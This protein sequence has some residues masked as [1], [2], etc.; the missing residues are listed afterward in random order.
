MSRSYELPLFL[1]A[2]TPVELVTR[3]EDYSLDGS[4]ALLHCETGSYH[5]RIYSAYGIPGETVLQP[6]TP[7]A[8]ATLRLDFC[9]AEIVRLRYSP[10]PDVPD[11]TT[12]MVVGQF[13]EPV[14]VALSDDDATVTFETT[15]LRVVVQRD[16]W[17]IQ[18]YN[19]QNRCI[20]RTRPVEL[21]PLQRAARHA[22]LTEQH[23]LFVH[24][25]AYPLGVAPETNQVFCSF[26]LHHDERIY[27][28]GGTSG[29]LDKHGTAQRLWL[30]AAAGSASPATAQQ[31]PFFM[32]SAGYGL[33][34]NT[35]NALRVNVGDLDHTAMSVLL[36]DST[37]LDAYLIYGPTMRD[38]LPRYTAIT[39]APTTPPRW[40]FGLWMGGN[41]YGSRAEVEQ[42]A[43]DLR[44]RGIPCD[45]LHIDTTWSADAGVCDWRFNEERF[46]DPATMLADL[47][48]QGF[49]VSL[50]QPPYLPVTS[51]AFAEA[52][53]KGLLVQRASDEGQEHQP[54][55]L[56]AADDEAALLDYSNPATVAW[57]R[58]KLHDLFRLGVAALSADA[59]EAAPADG[60]YHTLESSAAHNRYPLHATQALFAAGEA[61]FGTG[62]SMLRARSAWAGT[63]RFSLQGAS[64]SV[65]RFADL[66]CVLR[67]MLSAGLSGF[68][69]YS[70]DIGGTIGMP[71]P[72]LYI[73][74]A[75]MA[76]FSSH[77]RTHGTPPREPWAYGTHAEA[78]FRRYAELRYQLLPYI[79]SEAIECGRHSLP[80]VRPL[81]L[82]Y[83]DDP[84]TYPI[85]DQ[86]LFGSSL[87]IAPVLDEQERRQVYLPAGVWIDYW[88]KQVLPGGLWIEVDAPLDTL[89]MYVR[90]GAI[91]PY[92]PLIQH[93]E[94]RVSNPL[95]IELY[96]PL[97][98]EPGLEL[99]GTYTVY[100]DRHRQI[101]IG[102]QYRQRQRQLTVIVGAAPGIV[103]LVVYVRGL[104]PMENAMMDDLFQL[105][106]EITPGE[107]SLVRFDGRDVHTITL[108]APREE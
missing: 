1:G 85:D 58:E 38:M 27:G 75:Q 66:P 26:D 44:T 42:V 9:T 76:L 94:E 55:L 83:Q 39:G 78:I 72:E 59:G 93:S 31:V 2:P 71:T 48:T 102:Y 25:A 19:R 99:E 46:P 32:S 37:R 54:Y 92:G 60:V 40:S 49:R 98:Y 50:S 10:G 30:H 103:E 95:R 65:A 29:Q 107:A 82:Y 18:V 12:P 74:W 87:L 89:P 20:W 97:L 6:V 36:D 104:P 67:G 70:Q 80:M 43:H 90:G 61:F 88:T 101:P 28:F 57:I 23:W 21:A 24:R 73:R 69:F 106:V 91:V 16:P 13:S 5:P 7:A 62:K 77:V 15:A 4:T 17:Q 33:F 11:Q 64:E 51:P 41:S 47:H 84:N 22:N 105:P 86:Y 68:P 96:L 53:Q 45:G 3:L 56:P 79:Y 35:S 52:Q 34:L 8:P 81:M 63:Q 100:D 108:T 14:P